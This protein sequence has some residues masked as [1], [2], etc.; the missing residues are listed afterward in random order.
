M[1][2]KFYLSAT[3]PCIDKGH[4]D[5]SYNDPEDPN[6]PGFALLPAKGTV[7]ND[8]G[9]F[10]GHSGMT[11]KVIL[12]VKYDYRYFDQPE[13]N[14]GYVDSCAGF[15]L[16]SYDNMKGG[17]FTNVTRD[18]SPYEINKNTLTQSRNAY[19]LVRAF[20][21]TGDTTYLNYADKALR[22]MY[23]HGWD[24]QY[25]GWFEQL[26]DNG[27]PTDPTADKTAFF[28]HYAL[29]GIAAYYEA[30]R[31]T[32]HLHWLE[33]GFQHLQ[34][35]FWDD[36][37]GFEG[38]Y[39][40]V[41]YNGSD[42]SGKSFNAT[43]DA[44]TT[45]GL[46]L[47]QMTG[48]ENYL[49]HLRKLAD[50]IINHLVLSMPAQ[51]VGFA[52]MYDSD[53]QPDESD[54]ITLMGH[55]LKTAWCLA[56]IDQIDPESNYLEDAEMV[57]KNV[58]DHGYDNQYG[59]PYDA[60]DRTTGD[61]MIWTDTTKAWWQM[62][63]A[64]L[65]GLQLYNLSGD[66]S[67]KEIARESSGFF[68]ANFVDREYGE[69]Y[70]NRDRYGQS[71]GSD[72]KGDPYKAGYHSI[73]TGYYTYLY[74]ML[75]NDEHNQFDLHYRIAPLDS[76]RRIPLMPVALRPD[77]WPD[78]AVNM[79]GVFKDGEL[80]QNFSNDSMMLDLP[81]GTGG[82]F[83]VRFQVISG[84][85]DLV[86][87]LPRSFKLDQNFP[88]PFNPRTV[89]SWQLA[90]SSKVDLGIYNNLGQR[91]ATL[92]SGKQPAGS[93]QI[94]WDASDFSSGIYFYQLRTDRDFVQTKKLILLK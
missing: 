81:A 27:N 84:M 52:E 51:K 62:E 36:R 80:Y 58:L 55:V 79:V 41:D 65:G 46:A 33:K 12:E 94:E 78:W 7:R 61:I 16:K 24:A 13:L 85:E 10:G 47:Y 25:G 11:R 23:Q 5:E 39:D 37:T 89:I 54:K 35:T 70:A 82:D 53:W 90:V 72:N 4:P 1:D 32:F 48:E 29:L 63:Q 66:N 71:T 76:N 45:H 92:V 17:F 2:N 60:Y 69:I 19:G 93:Y 18:G 73:E 88:N 49:I 87:E 38:Y 86:T 75:F 22:F 59:G 91:V 44:I 83:T 20:M 64:I 31:D 3:S 26:D 57:F 30:T 14:I 67:D 9:A 56:R 42:P 50:Q 40:R 77:A 74:G 68:M 34:D 8:M 6:N 43:V 28:Q 15:W 21:M